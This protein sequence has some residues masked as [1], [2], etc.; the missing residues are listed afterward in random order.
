MGGIKSHHVCPPF[1]SASCFPICTDVDPG[2]PL[3]GCS[4]SSHMLRVQRQGRS[5]PLQPLHP[6]PSSRIFNGSPS[7]TEQLTGDP[8]TPAPRLD[9]GSRVRPK[10]AH[11]NKKLQEPGVGCSL[12][13]R[14]KSEGSGAAVKAWRSPRPPARSLGLCSLSAPW[15]N[16]LFVCLSPL[17]TLFFLSGT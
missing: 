17:S 10:H 12:S 1:L 14:H 7:L 5:S 16:S 4:L 2:L 13:Y 6:P 9:Q 3:W 8:W 11:L 15:P